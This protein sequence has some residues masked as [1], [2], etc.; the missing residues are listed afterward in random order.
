MLLAS[1]VGGWGK[2]GGG[3]AVLEAMKKA[4]KVKGE[5]QFKAVGN[6]L[7][8]FQFS[9]RLD[10]LKAKRGGPWHFDHN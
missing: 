4:W 8:F 2:G 1:F 7:F 9:Y 6:N 3:D 5:I 10:L